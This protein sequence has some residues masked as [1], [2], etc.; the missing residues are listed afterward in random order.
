MDWEDL[1]DE[2]IEVIQNCCQ[3]EE[4]EAA[5]RKHF[6]QKTVDELIDDALE[7]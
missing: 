4:D 5:A 3:T 6:A 1:E 7:E 2:L